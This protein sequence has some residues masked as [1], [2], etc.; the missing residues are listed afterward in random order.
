VLNGKTLGLVGCGRI[1]KWMARYG[2]AFGMRV[3]GYDPY[4]KDW[5]DHLIPVSLPELMSESH[6]VSIHVHLTDETRHIIG[7]KELGLVKRGTILINTARGA[8]LDEDAL[9]TALKDGRI[10]A[11]GCD[12]IEGEPQV[13]KTRLWQY[14]QDHLDCVITPHIGGFSPDALKVVLE[15]TAQRISDFFKE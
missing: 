12:V 15:F 11:V 10:A 9:L 2:H 3:L 6:F 1:G 14:A 13:R 7:E 4:N 5:P 8:V